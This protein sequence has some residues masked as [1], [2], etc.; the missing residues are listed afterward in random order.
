MLTSTPLAEGFPYRVIYFIFF[1][2]FPSAAFL[3]GGIFI[4]IVEEFLDIKIGS[5]GVCPAHGH[6]PSYNYLKGEME[7][8]E[9]SG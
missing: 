9:D 7:E 3:N 2:L 4:E 6:V 8:L 1:F 5:S